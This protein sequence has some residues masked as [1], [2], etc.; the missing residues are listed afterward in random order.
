MHLLILDDEKA[1][2]TMIARTARSVGWTSDSAIT[3][4]EF[5][6]KIAEV[7][8]DAVCLDLAL[9]AA[10]GIEE[11]RHLHKTGFRRPIVLMS[12][13]DDRV[14]D[15]ARQL[16]ESLGL[17]IAMVLRKPVR[18]AVLRE[19]LDQLGSLAV[20]DAPKKASVPAGRDIAGEPV[21]PER[22]N[23]AIDNGE[24]AIELQPM[25]D[26]DSF[27]VCRLEALIR[28]IHPFAGRIMPGDFIAIAEHDQHIIDKLTNWVV[29]AACA[30]H[31]RLRDA[32]FTV[33]IAVNI[34]GQNFHR[35]DFPDTMNAIVRGKGL[36]PSAVSFEITESVAL[37]NQTGTMDILTRL[38]LKGF[39]LAIDDLGTGFASLQ[40]LRQL[41]FT[42]MKIDRTFVSD[43]DS[44]RD[45][46]SIVRSIIGM[47][48]NM[49]VR[50]VAEGVED[51]ATLD[52]LRRLGIDYLQG[53][54][55][56]RP[57]PSHRVLGWMSEWASRP[58]ALV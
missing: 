41:P 50:C 56:E 40:A 28:W 53:Y 48:H 32:G 5:R 2:G 49:G 10:D 31:N 52:L 44:S 34:S 38:R 15:T 58:G 45:S 22:V 36:Q 47:A 13:F 9:G 7:P 8:P 19:M 55:I 24:M 16:G 29:G 39:E 1:I 17:I 12:G 18:I 26:A 27:R 6:A 20:P 11:L 43:A 3:P 54:V 46:L 57:M 14:L 37:A 51:L 35:L 25:V 4:E 33:P 30:E 23:A 21:T 42:E